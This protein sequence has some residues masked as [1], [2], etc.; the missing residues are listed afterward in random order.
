[1]P[2]QMRQCINCGLVCEVTLPR[3]LC[4]L[5]PPGRWGYARDQL[6]LPFAEG[7]EDDYL[8]LA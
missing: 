6:E 5:R 3:L 7:L 2:H 8:P 1:M 4:P